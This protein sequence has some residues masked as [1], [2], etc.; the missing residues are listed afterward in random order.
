[1]NEYSSFKQAFYWKLREV[2]HFGKELEVRG[3]KTKEICMEPFLIHNARVRHAVIP[4]RNLNP[5]AQIAEALWVFAGRDDMYWL[6]RYIPSCRKWSDNGKTWRGAYGPRLVYWP[7]DYVR[8]KEI[9]YYNQIDECRKRLIED[10]YTRQAIISIWDPARDNVIGSKDYPCNN[11]LH[12]I[13]RDNQLHLNVSI[14]SNDIW[15]GFSHA[16][17]FIW[18]MLQEMMAHW[19]GVEIGD[20]LW[21][22]TSFHLYKAQWDKV[23]AVGIQQESSG[24]YAGPLFKTD[25][26]DYDWKMELIFRAEDAMRH[27]AWTDADYLIDEELGQNRDLLFS[28]ACM[29]RIYNIHLEG[30]DVFDS[31]AFS[32]LGEGTPMHELAMEFFSR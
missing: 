18:S 28:M 23:E 3:S 25:W 31:K 10:P 1:M 7:S 15:F 30:H 21:N 27:G 11:W 19:V 5:F 22:A 4:G 2:Y 12:F 26:D 24:S 9:K 14:R 20:I 32:A 29:L 13:I 16:D 6:E 17:F 8:T